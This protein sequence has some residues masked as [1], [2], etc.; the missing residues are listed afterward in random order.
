MVIINYVIKLCLSVVLFAA[1]WTVAKAAANDMSR[2][3]SA[4]NDAL[5]SVEAKAGKEQET[6]YFQLRDSL[7]VGVEALMTHRSAIAIDT[8]RAS[9]SGIVQFIYQMFIGDITA[10]QVRIHEEGSAS[11]ALMVLKHRLLSLVSAYPLAQSSSRNEHVGMTLYL[12]RVI[13]YLPSDCSDILEKRV[14]QLPQTENVPLLLALSELGKKSADEALAKDTSAETKAL[15]YIF[16]GASKT[17]RD[18]KRMEE[19][20]LRKQHN[21][22][23]DGK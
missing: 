2:V 4:I 21:A 18:W 3:D 10:L 14:S 19:E 17:T 5:V 6:E 20:K 13:H 7:S 11:P 1:T 16:T 15:R 12:A 8:V 22:D 23:T 9:D